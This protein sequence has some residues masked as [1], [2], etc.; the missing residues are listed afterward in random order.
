MIKRILLAL[1]AAW[2]LSAFGFEVFIIA[3]L[4]EF[5]ITITTTGYYLIFAVTGLLSSI[6]SKN[7]N[8]TIHKDNK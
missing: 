5:G 6:F 7:T 8:I 4:A 1:F 2:I 3:G